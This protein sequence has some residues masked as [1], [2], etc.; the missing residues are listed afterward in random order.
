[1]FAANM[2]CNPVKKVLA[3]PEKKEKV[4]REWEKEHPCNNDTTFVTKSDTTVVTDTS[5][6][7]QQITATSTSILRTIKIYIP[8]SQII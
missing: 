6:V 8:E 5:I 3:D 4:G 2:A 7:W 1:M